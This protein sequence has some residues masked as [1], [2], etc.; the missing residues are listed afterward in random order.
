M[1]SEN[2]NINGRIN[3]VHKRQAEIVDV[4]DIKNLITSA[5]KA[6][7]AGLALSDVNVGSAFDFIAIG[8]G[9]TVIAVGDTA[10]SSEITTNGG[11]RAAA[12]GTRVQTSVGSDTAQLAL[13]YT[14]AG[15]FAVVESGIFNASTGGIMLAR[16]GFAALNVVSGDTLTV[17]WKVQF[18]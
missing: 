2:L 17:T 11:A 1:D 9:S 6:Q 5:G 18:S 4:R 3:F 12:T 15:A 16:Q 13:T 14:F 10:L 7:M 8:I